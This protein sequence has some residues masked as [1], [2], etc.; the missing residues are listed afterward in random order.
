M[1]LLG[2]ILCVMAMPALA[3]DDTWWLKDE[4]QPQGD[5]E[6]VE[7]FLS[8]DEF[9]GLRGRIYEFV[10]FEGPFARMSLGPEN[11]VNWSWVF[12][13]EV[14]FNTCRKGTWSE[15]S[16]NRVCF[17]FEG[18]SEDMC[19]QFLRSDPYIHARDVGRP[20][21]SFEWKDESWLEPVKGNEDECH[22]IKGPQDVFQIFGQP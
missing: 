21:P 7:D 17:S 10:D 22:D 13:Q 3:Q 20:G 12:D 11:A 16:D 8:V 19:W 6:L 14:H 9:A 5:M 4:E 2:M 15:A 1:R 18:V